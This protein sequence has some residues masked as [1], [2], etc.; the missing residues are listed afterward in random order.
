MRSAALAEAID[1]GASVFPV[2][3]CD[4]VARGHALQNIV[5]STQGRET[6]EG[7]VTH[8]AV[9]GGWGSVRIGSS[10]K[11]RR[12]EAV[13]T[14]VGVA[15]V[16]GSLV[17]LLE[18]YDPRGS[19]A[20]YDIAAPGL[21]SDDWEPLFRGVL[22]DWERRG[23]ATILVFK[24]DDTVLRTPVPSGVFT[25][26]EWGS[27]SE[28]TIYG[29]QMP[30]VTGVHDSWDVTQRGMVPAVNIRYDKDIGYWW[31]ISVDQL[32]SVSRVYFDGEPQEDT[33]WTLIQGVYGGNRCSILSVGN[34]Y[35]PEKG[36]VVSV[37]C[38][39]P[40]GLLTQG[41]SPVPLTGAPNQLRMIVEEYAY[42]RPPLQGWRGDHAIV[43]DTNWD[44]ASQFF[45]ARGVES[46]RRFGGDQNDVSV[47]EVIDSFLAA[48]HCV[49]IW[50]NELGEIDIAII[51]PD[52]VDP[53]TDAWL[54]L[55]A[56]HEGQDF[57]F[58]P[59]DRREVYTHLI[60][61]FMYSNS[62]QKFLTA[63]EAHDVA[64]LEEKVVLTID[65]PWSQCRFDAGTLNPASEDLPYPP[66][67]SPSASYSASV[68]PS[69]S[70]SASESASLSPSESPSYSA[71]ASVSPS[72]SPSYSQSLSSSL[73]PS[74]SP[75]ASISPSVS[76]SASPSVSPSASPSASPSVSPSSSPSASASASESPS[77][78]PSVSPSA[79]P[80]ASISPSVSPSA[81]PSVSPSGSPS[82]SPSASESA[83]DSPSYSPSVSPSASPSA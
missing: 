44:T 35:V 9:P 64:A 1:H 58:A 48:F 33:I 10:I 43:A 14:A 65:N 15:D 79:S 32:V 75:S 5:V 22:A 66:S 6:T 62:E 54:D 36:A 24:T 47:A 59:G 70:P 26:T 40:N 49:M 21:P 50:W 34:D 8:V 80:S 12:L 73:S 74:A 57:P 56:H 29:T 63:Y 77:Y 71:S 25:R 19:A 16:D 20:M 3:R 31:L 13:E 7:G 27:A 60:M 28:P 81:S 46:A 2:L 38:E 61:P 72:A 82:S 45:A 30:L 83:S 39:G 41:A 55:G 67:Q 17:S 51:D 52:D 23:L 42:R 11:T 69:R 18:T 53:D 78:S 68:S 37:D 76:P 4:L